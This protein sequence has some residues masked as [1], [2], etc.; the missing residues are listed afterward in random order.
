MLS[1]EQ[2]VQNYIIKNSNQIKK[3][4]QPLQDHFGIK[5]FTYHR[6]DNDGKYTVLLDRPEWAEHYVSQQIFLLDPYLRHPSVYQSGMHLVATQGTDEYREQVLSSGKQVLDMDTGIL[7]I[8]KSSDYVEFFGYSGNK[9]NS[10][11]ES[12]YLNHQKVLNSFAQHFK[13]TMKTLLTKMQKE[14]SSL[15]HLKGPDYLC[16]IPIHANIDSEACLAFYKDIGM[17]QELEMMRKL[18]ERERDCLKLLLKDN[19]AKETAQK[20]GLSP[21]TVEFYFENIK[22]KLSCINK[23]EILKIA[24]EFSDAGLLI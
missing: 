12:L 7:V 15:L 21:R 6:I 24:R 20:L 23:K 9:S 1:W 14:A 8:N 22:N 4:T 11:L 5:Y 2:I 10:A 18:S 17:E 3:A 16:D 13:R 19:S